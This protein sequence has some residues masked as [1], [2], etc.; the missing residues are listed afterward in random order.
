MELRDSEHIVHVHSA[1]TTHVHIDAKHKSHETRPQKKRKSHSLTHTQFPR[2]ER[3][4]KNTHTL[5]LIRS[6]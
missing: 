5:Q 2:R 4:E 3:A 6:F 1:H